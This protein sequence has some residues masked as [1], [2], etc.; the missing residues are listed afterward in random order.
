M[1]TSLAYIVEVLIGIICQPLGLSWITDP[2]STAHN[3]VDTLQMFD[4][5]DSEFS[6]TSSIGIVYIH[7]YVSYA[8]GQ[9]APMSEFDKEQKPTGALTY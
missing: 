1:V 3:I 2:P 6:V 9:S 8:A 5:N 7:S 4:R